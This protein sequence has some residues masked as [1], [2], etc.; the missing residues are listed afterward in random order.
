M[1]MPVIARGAL[2]CLLSAA[3][4]GAM[5][6]FGKLAFDDGATAGTL[7]AARFLI[8]ALALWC[9]ML[10]KGSVSQIRAIAPRDLAIAVGLGACGYALQAACYF[11]ALQH[12]DASLLSL[13][14]YTFP[15]IVTV[16]AVALGRERLD[17]RR[18]LALGLVSTGLVLIL[19]TAG[20]SGVNGVGVALG[21]GAAITYSTYILTSD[22]VA[23]R[24]PALTLATIVCTGAA[25]SLTIGSVLTGQLHPSD[26]TLAGWGWLGCIALISTVGAITLFFA[27]LRQVGPT[28]ASILSTF[29]PVVTVVLAAAVLA[30]HLT[31]IQVAGGALVLSAVL[32]LRVGGFVGPGSEREPAWLVDQVGDL[33]LAVDRVVLGAGDGDDGAVGHPAG[34]ANSSPVSVTHREWPI[35]SVVPDKGGTEHDQGRTNGDP[36]RERGGDDGGFADQ[37]VMNAHPPDEVHL[38]ARCH[39]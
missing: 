20:A 7:L 30:E 11:V 39:R 33:A 8:A 29:E 9:L 19:G 36:K 25:T 17:R 1:I 26:V 14:L 15:A 6:V 21:L 22:G 32:V 24:I 23:S 10:I 38:A 3:A 28:S 16:A 12:L 4:F 34:V 2:V 31:P 13:I 27:G 35:V 18:L 37:A 5:G